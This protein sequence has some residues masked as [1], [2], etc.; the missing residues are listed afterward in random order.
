LARSGLVTPPLGVPHVLPWRIKLRRRHSERN[1]GVF[2]M[3]EIGDRQ[4]CDLDG[5]TATASSCSI[6]RRVGHAGLE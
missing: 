1:P 4:C 2:R 6:R 5:G 3:N